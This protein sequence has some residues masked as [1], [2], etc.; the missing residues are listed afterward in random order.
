MGHGLA[1]I[2]LYGSEGGREG[3]RGV[4]G[5]YSYSGVGH[6]LAGIL[7]WLGRRKGREGGREG[8]G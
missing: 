8:G 2:L 1:D 6:R 4:S 3:E 7:W 5:A